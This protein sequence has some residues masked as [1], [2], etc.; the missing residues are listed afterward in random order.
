MIGKIT[1]CFR[2][3]EEKYFEKTKSFAHNKNLPR[4]ATKSF[5]RGK[6][7]AREESEQ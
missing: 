7:C 3:G 5:A 4:S 2:R 6:K 1:R